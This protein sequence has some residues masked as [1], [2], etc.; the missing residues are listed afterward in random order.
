M[1]QINFEDFKKLDIRVG[2]IISAEKIE[3][4]DKLLKLEVDFG[5]SEEKSIV[6]QIIAGIA[7]FYDTE[8]LIGKECPFAYNLA[9]RNLKGF[10]SQGMILCP[11]DENGPVLL[12]PDK[13][14]P[15]GS[16]IK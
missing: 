2:K 12:H 8:S 16:S 4:S 5:K 6:R 3:G 14:V 13:E 15:P 10:E 9:P 11:F 1:E 7:Q